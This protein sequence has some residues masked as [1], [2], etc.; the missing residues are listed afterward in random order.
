MVA[1]KKKTIYMKICTKLWKHWL[2]RRRISWCVVDENVDNKFSRETNKR[3]KKKKTKNVSVDHRCARSLTRDHVNNKCNSIYFSMLCYYFLIEIAVAYRRWCILFLSSHSMPIAK[4][5]SLATLAYSTN[6]PHY[7][8]I[9]Y[10][11]QS[12]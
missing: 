1:H 8:L 4:C 3:K 11:R 5:H 6:H 12:D 10:L 7:L 9:L 2:A